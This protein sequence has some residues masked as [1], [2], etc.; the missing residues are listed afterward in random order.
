[1]TS[2]EV[3]VSVAE[4]LRRKIQEEGKSLEDVDFI[5]V[6]GL[7]LQTDDFWKTAELWKWDINQLKDEFK[8][9]FKDRTWIGKH[10]SRNGSVRLKYHKLFEEPT[11]ILLHPMPSEF[12]DG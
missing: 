2:D 8:I 10:Y 11:C 1:M 6:G 7:G 12:L 5:S 4:A 9:V 3:F